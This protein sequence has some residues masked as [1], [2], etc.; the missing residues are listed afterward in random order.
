[1]ARI[2]SIKPTFFRS[3]S[4]KMLSDKAKL[5]WIGLWNLADDEGRLVDEL[6]ILTGDLWALAVTDA[7]LDRALDEL[8]RHGRIVRYE[9]AGQAYIQV[10]GWEHQRINRATPSPIPHFSLSDN[11]VSAHAPLTAGKEGIGRD[12]EGE[13]PTGA[14]PPLFCPSHPRGTAGNCRP[15]ADARRLHDQWERTVKANVKPTVVGIVTELDCEL[16]PFYPARDCPRCTEE[17][18]AS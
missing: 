12:K 15:C 18:V 11:S 8:H 1:M 14:A 9:V 6:G 2:R 16:H 10:T 13:A 4:V 17:A 7:K 5:V 3:R